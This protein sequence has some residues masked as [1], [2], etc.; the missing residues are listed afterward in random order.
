[1]R[2]IILILIFAGSVFADGWK[3][4]DPVT[5]SDSSRVAALSDSAL[6]IPSGTNPTTDAAGEIAI[7]TDDKMLEFYDGSTSIAMPSYCAEVFT[8]IE[9]DSIASEQDT[10]ALF[11]FDDLLCP[12]GASLAKVQL[13]TSSAASDSVVLFEWSDRA[14]TSK[15]II[16]TLVL[17]ASQD[18]EN[19]SL[20]DSDIASDSWLVLDLSLWDANVSDMEIGIFYLIKDGD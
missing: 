6:T 9:P 5:Y 2:H 19:T 10:L 4:V 15:S 3:K 13:S 7:D 16:D 12:H 17:S 14:G 11:N 18:V 8:L 20:N 1:M